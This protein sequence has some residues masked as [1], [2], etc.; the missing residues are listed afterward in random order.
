MRRNRAQVGV[1]AEEDVD[2]VDHA[3]Q[4]AFV[5]RQVRLSLFVGHPGDGALLV[6]CG[7]EVFVNGDLFTVQEYVDVGR[8]LDSLA[9]PGVH[10]EDVMSALDQVPRVLPGSFTAAASL[11][12]QEHCEFHRL[13]AFSFAREAGLA[14]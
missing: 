7:G 13:A 1:I 11:V 14:G 3:F 10:E 8:A 5:V 12:Q 4:G 9:D 6:A 2:L